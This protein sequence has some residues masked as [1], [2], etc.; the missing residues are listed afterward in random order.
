MGVINSEKRRS[1]AH[2]FLQDDSQKKEYVPE[3]PDVSA[4]ATEGEESPTKKESVL[5]SKK[6]E[7]HEATVAKDCID[8]L[9]KRHYGWG[10]CGGGG[11]G[12]YGGGY[13]GYGGGYGGYG[14]HGGGFGGHG[15]GYGGYGGY[16]GHGHGGHGH[17]EHGHDNHDHG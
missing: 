12:G 14:G 13:G 8:G 15:G 7:S 3:T 16:G 10:G 2:N 17:H 11:Y 4:V 1:S 6:E 5:D 9:G